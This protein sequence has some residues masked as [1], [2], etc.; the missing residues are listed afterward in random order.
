M[1]ELALPAREELACT[2]EQPGLTQE[3]KHVRPV[4]ALNAL[5]V[6]G[7]LD[8]LSCHV[9]LGESLVTVYQHGCTYFHMCD[10]ASLSSGLTS[11]FTDT[12]ETGQRQ[13]EWAVG[14]PA[15]AEASA[16][17]AKELLEL[18]A[19]AWKDKVCKTEQT[20]HVAAPA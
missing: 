18:H 17:Y 3:R 2:C 12:T 8:V 15:A 7:H 16:C 19:P 14:L 13:P 10:H 11:L 5:C 20:A 9:Q 1:H 6:H 4:Q